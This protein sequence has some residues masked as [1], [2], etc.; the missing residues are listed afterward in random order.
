MSSFERPS[1]SLDWN[2][3]CD[4]AIAAAVERQ[5]ELYRQWRSAQAQVQAAE[6][7]VAGHC[8]RSDRRPCTPD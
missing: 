6:R 7:G 3:R 2:V 4:P 8:R 1:S 5:A